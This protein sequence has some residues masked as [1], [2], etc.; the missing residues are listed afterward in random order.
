M[1]KQE[2]IMKKQDLIDML[3]R[4]WDSIEEIKSCI[5]GFFAYRAEP[6]EFIHYVIEWETI[7]SKMQKARDMFEPKQKDE[8]IKLYNDWRMNPKADYF[9]K[10]ILWI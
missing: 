5:Q 6:A 7:E 4:C 9:I 3:W 8:I 10:N 1:T 2:I